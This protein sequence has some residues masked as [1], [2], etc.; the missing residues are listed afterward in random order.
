MAYRTGFPHLEY[1]EEVVLKDKDLERF[2]KYVKKTDTC[3][4]WVGYITPYGYGQ[5]G[6][7]YVSNQAHRLSYLHYVGEIPEG[8]ILHHTCNVKHCVNPEHLIPISSRENVLLGDGPTAVNFR[9]EE[10]KRGH[11]LSGSNL[12]IDGFGHR[13]C[14]MCTYLYN[15][16]GG[17]ES[18]DLECSSKRSS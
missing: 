18:I 9:K 13:R 6:I 16:Y 1:S 15:K 4:I 5:F 17:V 8:K 14:R 11:P 7:E 2:L 3:W 12:Y 10:C